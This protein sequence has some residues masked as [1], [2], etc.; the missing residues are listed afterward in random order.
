VR[1]YPDHIYQDHEDHEDR[2]DEQGLPN[3]RWV[4]RQR[5][6]VVRAAETVGMRNSAL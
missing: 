4:V 1:E 3:Q 5:D 2:E 6:R